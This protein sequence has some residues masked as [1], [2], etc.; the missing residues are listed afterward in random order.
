MDWMCYRDR[1]SDLAKAYGTNLKGLRDH[2]LAAG[3]K[4]GRDPYCGQCQAINKHDVNGWTAIDTAKCIHRTSK[5]SCEPSC[6]ETIRGTNE[7]GY[8]G[9][10]TKTISGRTCQKWSEQKPH[11]HSFSNVAG[12][13]IEGGHN[14]ARNPSGHPNLWCYTTDSR[15]RWENAVPLSFGTSIQKAS[16]QCHAVVRNDGLHYCQ[17]NWGPTQTSSGSA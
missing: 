12:R 4:E 8:R 9:C 16:T 3:L 15:V 17:F 1:Y 11:A 14:Y 5:S 2:Y 7:I 6:D 10:Q 13:G